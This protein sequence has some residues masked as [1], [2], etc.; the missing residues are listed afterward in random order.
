M[1]EVTT[2]PEPSGAS[3]NRKPALKLV[4][5]PGYGAVV[6][7][8]KHRHAGLGVRSDYD[9]RWCATLNAVYL[10]AVEFA[11]AATDFPIAFT[12]EANTGHFLPVAV[13][14]LRQDEN[15][16]VDAA[17]QW[18]EF[19]YIPAY[20][21]RHPFCI[22]EL[23]GTDGQQPR[24]LVCVQEDQLGESDSPLF[25]A[26]GEATPAWETAQKL[27]EAV[28]GARQQT[29][30]LT[31]KLEA[32][33]LL[34][35]FDALATARGGRQMRLQGMFR[36]DEEKLARVPARDLTQMIGKGQ[37]RCVYAHLISLENFARLLDLT[38]ARDGG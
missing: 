4:S 5:P 30:A 3:G 10:N 6:P 21:R 15:L 24:R 35:P 16:F 38:T 13:L 11:R 36:V 29:L 19:S 9:Y 18:R 14:G 32:L 2:A 22:A 28:E 37:L 31:R 33:E 26:E 27:L 20:F 7:L 1:N 34:V 12:R 8:D 17:G 23:A 25:T